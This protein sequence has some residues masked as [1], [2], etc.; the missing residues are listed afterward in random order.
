MSKLLKIILIAS[1]SSIIFILGALVGTNINKH[2]LSEGTE[3]YN[4]RSIAIVN[5]D[6]GVF[7]EG[8]KIYYSQEILELPSRNFNITSLDEANFGVSNGKYAA[9]VIL[10]SSFSQSI[11]SINEK[12]YKINIEYKLSNN[13]DINVKDE[14]VLDIE[15]FKSKLSADISYIYLDAIMSEF[16]TVQDNSKVVLSNDKSELDNIEAMKPED[17]FINA[18]LPE[19]EFTEL[20]EVNLGTESIIEDNSKQVKLIKDTL[21]ANIETGKEEYDLIIQDRELLSSHTEDFFNVLGDMNIE[22]DDNGQLIYAEGKEKLIQQVNRYNS[23]ITANRDSMNQDISRRNALAKSLYQSYID[24]NTNGFVQSVKDDLDLKLVMYKASLEARI[25]RSLE[26]VRNADNNTINA[27]LSNLQTWKDELNTDISSYVN[28]E[29]SAADTHYNEEL[30]SKLI[31]YNEEFIDDLISQGYVSADDKDNIIQYLEEGSDLSI[32]LEPYTDDENISME[33]YESDTDDNVNL[34]IELLSVDAI[35]GIQDEEGGYTAF[36]IPDINYEL[37]TITITLPEGTEGIYTDLVDTI[38]AKY[39]LSTTDIEATVLNDIVAVIKNRAKEKY[40]NLQTVMNNLNSSFNNY[41]DRIYEFNPY[42]YIDMAGL[43]NITFNINSNVS[44]I[45]SKSR[46][47]ASVKNQQVHDVVRQG[48]DH[49]ESLRSTLENSNT[50]NFGLV[51]EALEKI[52]TNRKTNNDNNKLMMESFS[53]KLPYTRVGSI[54]NK[55]ALDFIVK[56]ISSEE[57]SKSGSIISSIIKDSSV[58]YMY[59]ICSI[60]VCV[61]STV[62]YL[63][64]ELR[65]G[66]NLEEN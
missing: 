58:L 2:Y 7:V 50:S 48:F 11:E 57:I 24:S 59:L 13:L 44:S 19:L 30:S 38:E 4:T 21:D 39:N 62:I 40:T 25:R 37:P 65:R 46:E 54:R 5:L 51:S 15:D 34:Q 52:K 1:V 55:E 53:D 22:L 42:N 18:N 27:Y 23:D 49:T 9:Y 36:S 56:P 61:I 17:M 6:D 26:L 45:D 60:A 66:G 8:K 31:T 28:A 3:L 32:N 64:I 29:I 33:D 63:S 47:Y 20:Q 35:Y 16:H 12:P 41:Q 43:N 14:V 10:P